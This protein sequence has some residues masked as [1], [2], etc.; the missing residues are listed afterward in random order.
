MHEC[1]GVG[2]GRRNGS[3][4]DSCDSSDYQFV[5]R[6]V[7]YGQTTLTGM[8]KT[9]IVRVCMCLFIWLV[10]LSVLQ[11]WLPWNLLGR[12]SWPRPHKDPSTS[13]FQVLGLELYTT[14]PS[15]ELYLNEKYMRKK[16]SLP[17]FL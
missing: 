2:R 5:N 11:R 3:G 7:V 15:C 4:I 1:L 12:S 9:T 10:F 8:L 13:A 17:P 14:M 6:L 16:I